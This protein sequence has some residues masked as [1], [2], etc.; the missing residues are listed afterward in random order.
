MPRS[1]W[2]FAALLANNSS[3]VA[4]SN[5][6][7][8]VKEDD[9]AKLSEVQSNILQKENQK[10]TRINE[11]N[12]HP[13]KKISFNANDVFSKQFEA[14]KSINDLLDLATIP[15][16]STNDAL[17]LISHITKQIN[18]GKA[19]IVDVEADERF[20]HLR[21]IV[22]TN[23]NIKFGTKKLS[24]D[25]SQYSKL[26]TPAM[27]SVM[28]SLRDQG[29]R[30]TPLLRM[31]S[32]NIVK[33]NMKLNLKQCASLLYSMAVLNFPDKVLLE[34]IMNDLLIC[35]PNT[36]MCINSVTSKSILTSLGFLFYKNVDVLDAFCDAVFNESVYYKTHDCL[37]ILQTFAALQYKPKKINLFLEK[38]I[39]YAKK[40][41]T[42]DWLDVVWCLAV[43][44]VVQPQYIK[45]VLEPTFV[46]KLFGLYLLLSNVQYIRV[47]DEIKI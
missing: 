38:F 10:E 27:I 36:D 9:S 1:P 21:K 2:R 11:T 20:I 23:D 8:S 17:T 19:E 47:P 31:L 14:A 41:K 45:S 40:G 43:L 39:E 18:S 34:K 13:S 22:K 46:D 32:Y 15:A 3:T 42:A 37:S 16:L 4:T 28:A 35:I 7:T 30:N 44:D 29:K 6:A 33:Y 25:L 12:F 26:S 5:S 24:N